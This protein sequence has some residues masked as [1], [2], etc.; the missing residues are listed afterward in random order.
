MMSV[1]S[2][3]KQ[4]EV[5]L[6]PPELATIFWNMD[7]EEQAIF[8][9][10]LGLLSMHKLCLQMCYVAQSPELQ[11]CGKETMQKIGEWGNE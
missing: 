8:F 10:H 5:T 7:S 1:K 11:P 6:T 9:N 3:T 4:V 2:V